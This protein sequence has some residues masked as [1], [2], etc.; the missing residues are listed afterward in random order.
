MGNKN[1]C[2][3]TI[4]DDPKIGRRGKD[5]KNK[6]DI[7]KTTNKMSAAAPNET[8]DTQAMM[9]SPLGSEAQE[10]SL[11]HRDDGGPR[12]ETQLAARE[13][14]EFQFGD[15]KYRTPAAGRGT[16]RMDSQFSQV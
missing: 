2:G 14:S 6:K 3:S 11:D 10:I 4:T 12:A 7:K 5:K 15:M 9:F 13:D 8:L 16:T 1:C